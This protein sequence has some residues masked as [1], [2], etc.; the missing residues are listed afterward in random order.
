MQAQEKPVFSKVTSVG[1]HAF[2]LMKR[3]GIDINPV[4]FELFYEMASGHNPELKRRFAALGRAMTRGDLDKLC[5]EF[6]PHHYGD[7]ILEKSYRSIR[8][9]LTHFQDDL[10]ASKSS[11]TD[12]TGALSDT[13]KVL[14][15]IK[16]PEIVPLK[17]QIALVNKAAMAQQEQTGQF[18][19]KVEK[20]L[21]AVNSMTDE[22]DEIG[23]AKFCDPVT[24]LGNRRA[25]LKDMAEYYKPDRLPKDFTL[26]FASY[27]NFQVFSQPDLARL[28]NEFLVRMITTNAALVDDIG[29]GYWL[30]RPEMAYVI[31]TTDDAEIARF[32]AQLHDTMAREI[33]V[34]RGSA[35]NLPAIGM[36]FGCADSYSGSNAGDVIR[37]AETALAD[38]LRHGDGKVVIFGRRDDAAKGRDYALYGRQSFAV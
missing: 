20:R 5:Q 32:A 1:D 7:T 14:T 36:T 19:E 25:F 11:L 10:N 6:L 23:R 4:T 28:R 16:S 15:K 34:L 27:L 18:I 35:K 31:E 24:G 21:S 12:F 9:E 22:L 17:A 13:T 30:D 8:D 26:V 3:L 2:A 38:A 29:K 37:N 33:N